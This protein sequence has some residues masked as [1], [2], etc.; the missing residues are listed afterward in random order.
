M[1]KNKILLILLTIAMLC[2]SS[3]SGKQ[4]PGTSRM[5]DTTEPQE[6]QVLTSAVEDP[7]WYNAS[8]PIQPID[9]SDVAA[10]KNFVNNDDEYRK[11]VTYDKLMP[12]E[13]LAYDHMRNLLKER[14]LPL[15]VCYDL[16]ETE[17]G[18]FPEARY[19]DVGVNFTCDG[20]SVMVFIYY[21]RSDYE[22]DSSIREYWDWRFGTQYCEKAT[23]LTI[24]RNGKSLHA[25]TFP[26]SSR[27]AIS[28][29]EDR[30]EIRI[31]HGADM[32]SK[33]LAEAFEYNLVSLAVSD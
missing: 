23:E 8:I 33:A 13:A 1:M 9:V 16:Y 27:T 11:T 4:E 28:F 29:M 7:G 6:T 24:E 26:Y 32:D 5:P 20:G 17:I 21:V 30:Y 3:C 12:E 25:Q 2:T 22:G 18:L 19:E 31:L 15:P 14:K 10:L